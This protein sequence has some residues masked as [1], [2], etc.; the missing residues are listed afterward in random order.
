M[1]LGYVACLCVVCR[2]ARAE[3]KAFG[4]LVY[5]YLG[6]REKYTHKIY[7]ERECVCVY[8]ERVYRL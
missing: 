8:D 3:S 5:V 6:V 1:R 2:V 4:L 7:K